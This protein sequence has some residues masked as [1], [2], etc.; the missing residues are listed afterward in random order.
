MPAWLNDVVEQSSYF[1]PHGHCYLWIPSLLWLHVLSDLLIG[2]AYVGISLLLCLLVRRIRLPFSPVFIAFGLFIG[3]CGVTHFV[4][5]WTVWN[6][7]YLLAGL[8]KAAT[9][10]ASVATAIGLLYVRPKVEEVVHAARLSEER[11]IR[12]ESTNAE[13]ETLYKKVK[14]LDEIKTRFFANVSHE[15][16]TPL[17]LI[18]GPAERMLEDA[19]LTPEQQRQLQ[20]ISR[21]SKNLLRQVNDL[22]DVAKLEAGEMPVQYARLDLAAWLRRIASQ[23]ELAAEQRRIRYQVVA[24]ARLTAEVDPDMMERIVINLLSNAFKFTPHE[25][26]IRLEL[27]E[28]DGALRLSVADTGPGISADQQQMIFERFRQA[29][30]ARKFRGTGLGLAIV[31]ELVELHAGRIELASALGAGAEFV[32]RMPLS[33][34]PSVAVKA[35]PGIAADAAAQSAVRELADEAASDAID[36]QPA[37]A[38]NRPSVL[39]VEDNPEMSRFVAG[40]LGSDFN[41]VVAADGQEGLERAHALQPDLIVTDL[42]MPRMDG[43]QMIAALRARSGFASVPIILLTAK[44]DDELRVRLLRTGAQDYLVKPF[45]P[46]EL[47]ARASNLVAIKRA[48]DVLR[49][50]LAGASGDVAGLATE[51]ALK[52]RQLQTALEAAEVAREQAERASQVKSYFLGM[53]SHELRTPLAV[54]HMNAAILARS[55]D[56]QPMPA[57]FVTR[58][59]RLNRATQQIIALV[60]GLLEYARVESGQ[61]QPHLETVDAVVLATDVVDAHADNAPPDVRLVLEAPP[62]EMERALAGDPRLLRV[63]LSNLVSNALKFTKQGTVTVRLRGESEWQVF[64]V[65]DTGIGIAEADIARIF[66]PFEQLEPLQRKSIPGIGLGLALVKQIVEALHG[67][68]EVTSEPGAGSVFRI[69]LPRSPQ[70]AA[71]PL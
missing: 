60:E 63:A 53:V 13:L 35:A 14:E 61:V 55:V 70:S 18:L 1:M 69:R 24:P 42:M 30:G 59:D 32:V 25:G 51:L 20:V 36:E 41:V 48:G 68:I 12:L 11:R 62:A 34:P 37:Q 31:K 23:F 5:V 4:S 57:S 40:I 64:E 65:H 28:H 52:H 49:V 17:A 22:L 29:S 39:V 10:A 43:E 54:I 9:A 67:D 26:A 38:P 33:A 50:E 6:P 7:D 58:L 27:T 16:R 2:I 8:I 44:S 46:Q 56:G 71:L 66:L 45:L 19:N 21:N 3:L 47:S 15:L